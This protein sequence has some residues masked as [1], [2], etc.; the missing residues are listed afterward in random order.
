MKQ[1]INTNRTES[2]FDYAETE[3]TA[4][5]LCIELR[6]QQFVKRES[7]GAKKMQNQPKSG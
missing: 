3:A 4:A 7:K 1:K 5:E 6:T 2:G